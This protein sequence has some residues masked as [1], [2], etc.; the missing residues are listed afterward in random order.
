[1]AVSQLTAAVVAVTAAIMASTAS[2]L[3]CQPGFIR[4]VTLHFSRFKC[5]KMFDNVASTDEDQVSAVH[6]PLVKHLI[7]HESVTD[8]VGVQIHRVQGVELF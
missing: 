7:L 8:N 5:F 6:G 1:M 3:I 2:F 4:S